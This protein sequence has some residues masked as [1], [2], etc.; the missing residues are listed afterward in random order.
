M[1]PSPRERRDEGDGPTVSING[2]LDLHNQSVS[3]EGPVTDSAGVSASDASDPLPQQNNASSSTLSHGPSQ[4]AKVDNAS[5]TVSASQ[6]EA[7]TSAGTLST[8][9]GNVSHVPLNA[10]NADDTSKSANTSSPPDDQNDDDDD[11]DDNNEDVSSDDKTQNATLGGRGNLENSTREK[12]DDAGTIEGEQGPPR[13]GQDSTS[14]T[15]EDHATRPLHQRFQASKADEG[16]FSISKDGVLF[17]TV[18]W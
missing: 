3:T 11:D 10:T 13:Q 6:S 2:S 15:S 9:N 7:E 16:E 14:K 5:T 4:F 18:L 8:V 12:S 1:Y 17:E